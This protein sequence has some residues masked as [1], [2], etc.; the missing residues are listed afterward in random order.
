MN[1]PLV[2]VAN[3][4]KPDLIARGASAG[5]LGKRRTQT[6][7][8]GPRDNRMVL[9]RNREIRPPDGSMGGVEFVEGVR[10]VH[11]VQHVAVD[12]NEIAA[13]GATGH[14]VFVPN[15][16][17]Q[18]LRHGDFLCDTL[19]TLSGSSSAI[20]HDNRPSGGALNL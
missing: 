9:H 1:D 20:I 13:V 19:Q 17:D 4:E 12:V 15:F 10:S 18:S 11:L 14:E 2:G 5:G 16:I 8:A 7:G 3:V 6:V